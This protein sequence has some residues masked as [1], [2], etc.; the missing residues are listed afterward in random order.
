MDSGRR[1]LKNDRYGSTSDLLSDGQLAGDGGSVVRRAWSAGLVGVG[2]CI[3]LVDGTGFGSTRGKVQPDKA[4][5][6]A[7][8]DAHCA[9]QLCIAAAEVAAP[10][11]LREGAIHVD[12][13]VHGC[14]VRAAWASRISAAGSVF[15]RRLSQIGGMGFQR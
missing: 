10:V 12:M 11:G 3:A 7:V 5:Y 2:Q 8:Y 14:H 1:A 15:C 13:L 9:G 4:Y 6:C